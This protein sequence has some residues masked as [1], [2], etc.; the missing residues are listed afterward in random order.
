MERVKANDPNALQQMG[1]RHYFEGDY[2]TAFEYLTKAAELG[3]AAAHYELARMYYR[4]DGVEKDEEKKVYHWKRAAVGGHPYARHYLAYYELKNGHMER[5]V[6][7]F[8]IAANLGYEISMKELWKYFSAGYITKE[9]LEFTLRTHKAAIDAT[10]SVQ[11][12]EARLAA[13]Q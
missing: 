8:V 9:E 2:E 6:K 7:H 12:E 3:D 13:S 4:G 11:R 5:A 10:K 1:G